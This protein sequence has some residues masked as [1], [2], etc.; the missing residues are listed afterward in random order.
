GKEENAWRDEEPGKI[1]HEFRQG[2]LA[3]LGEIPHTPYY[4]SVDSTP[5]FLL[6]MSEYYKW[7]GD[8]EFVQKHRGAILAALEWIDTYGDLDGDGFVEYKRKSSRGLIN[9]GWKDSHNAVAYEDGQ[10][11]RA[12]IALA[13]VQAYVYYAKKRMAQLFMDLGENDFSLKLVKEAARLKEAFNEKFWIADQSFYAIALD[14]DK[15][16]VKT[17][18]SNAGQCLWTGIADH[19]KAIAV[20]KRLLNPDMFSG[21]GIR[22]VSKDAATYNPMS[23]HNGSIWPH[24]NSIIVRGLKRYGRIREAEHVATGIFEAAIYHSYHRLPE[25]FCGFTRRGSNSPVEYP[26]ACSPQAWAAG[27]IFMILQSILGLTANAPKNIL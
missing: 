1:M 23:Y 25:L 21:W 18:S 4:G 17:I 19:D 7:S 8:K 3:H 20:S 10:M 13:E 5:L 2:E 27:A 14:G 9:Q 12:P 22:T 15:N 26:V 24:D 11:A 16:Q 6:V